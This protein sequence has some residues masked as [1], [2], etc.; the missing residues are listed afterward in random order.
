V[1][2]PFFQRLLEA[3]FFIAHPE[4]KDRPSD[5]DW[6]DAQPDALRKR[7]SN[8][9][10][11]RKM[12]EL[13]PEKIARRKKDWAQRNAE[14]VNYYARVRWHSRPDVREQCAEKQ[15]RRKANPELRF[16]DS[17]RLSR[18]QYKNGRAAVLAARHSAEVVSIVNAL[19]FGHEHYRIE[20]RGRLTDEQWPLQDEAARWL[21]A[22]G[23]TETAAEAV[24]QKEGTP[25]PESGITDPRI[26]T[27]PA[28]TTTRGVEN[29]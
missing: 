26:D 11:S 22:H 20:R 13:Y 6:S 17:E 10:T 2:Q 16:R 7:E 27:A 12:R 28:A 25:P 9:A 24:S 21:A 1:S 8:K 3:C 5:F 29:L 4:A 23:D 15:R 18:R 19:N 14:E